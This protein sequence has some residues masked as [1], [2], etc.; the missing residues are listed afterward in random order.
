MRTVEGFRGDEPDASGPADLRG[1]QDPAL[2]RHHFA[3]RVPRCLGRLPQR[4]RRRERTSDEGVDALRC[5]RHTT[6]GSARTASAIRST[7]AGTR[8]ASPPTAGSTWRVTACTTSRRVNVARSTHNSLTTSLTTHAAVRGAPEALRTDGRLHDCGRFPAG[9]AGFG[10]P[11]LVQAQLRDVL[12]AVWVDACRAPRGDRPARVHRPPTA[13]RASARAR[14]SS[15]RPR[16]RL[17]RC[18]C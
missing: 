4:C 18:G 17:R 16:L 13:D 15:P 9:V 8:V 11:P 1:V 12:R 6:I 14:R 3:G 10:R 5:W 7:C 2:D